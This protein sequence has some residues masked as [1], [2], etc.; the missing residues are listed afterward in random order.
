ML[1]TLARDLELDT[2]TVEEDDHHRLASDV[3]AG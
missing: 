3:R 1:S 2:L